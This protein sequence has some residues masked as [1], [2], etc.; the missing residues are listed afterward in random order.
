MTMI[1]GLTGGI[2]SGKT[3]IANLFA[4][5]FKID[6]VDA[7][8]VA[9]EVVEP[10]SVG[11]KAIVEHFGVEML[12]QDGQ[13]NRA[14]LR[15]RIFAHPHDKQWINDLLHPLIR[16][17]I[18]QQLQSVQ[19]AYALL[20]VPLL[21]ENDWQKNIDRLL[22]IDVE[23]HT[24]IMRTC[25]RDG[26]TE[27]QARSIL[28]SQASREQRLSYA[29]DVINNDAPLDEQAKQ[30]LLSQVTVLH[31]KYLALSEQIR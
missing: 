25:Q 6:I 11:L 15:E 28:A 4:Q 29:D 16:Q 24:Q 9:R 2:G 18:D 14:Q 19:S 31:K 13:L 30:K 26:V 8:V 10:N 5:H 7:D 3:T 1:V 22:V 27:Q 23:P 12:T 21:I 20:V 17:R